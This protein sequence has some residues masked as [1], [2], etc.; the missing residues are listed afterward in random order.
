M[1]RKVQ[2]FKVPSRIELESLD[3]ESRVLT[4]TPWDLCS[5]YQ[6]RIIA[7]IVVGAEANNLKMIFLV[8]FV[9]FK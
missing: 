4:A 9:D 2:K 6:S 3:S 1:T 8:N 5:M 7:R